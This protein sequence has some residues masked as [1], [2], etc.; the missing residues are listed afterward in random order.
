MTQTLVNLLGN[1]KIL[2][3][4]KL[5]GLIIYIIWNLASQSKTLF[6]LCLRI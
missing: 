3:V 2:S 6:F 4:L 1:F 5:E